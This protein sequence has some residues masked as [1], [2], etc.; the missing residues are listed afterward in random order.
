[1]RGYKEICPF[2]NLEQPFARFK[3]VICE[4]EPERQ[5]EL[6][7]YSDMTDSMFVQYEYHIAFARKAEQYFH[8]TDTTLDWSSR[9]SSLYMQIFVGLKS[10]TCDLC[11]P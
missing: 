5:K 11:S 9:D 4:K 7:T 1:M 8:L 6:D 2:T 3:N 10:S